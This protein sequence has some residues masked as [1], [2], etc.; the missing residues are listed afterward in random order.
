MQQ[1]NVKISLKNGHVIETTLQGESDREIK[2]QIMGE[3]GLFNE[4][5]AFFFK[6]HVISVEALKSNNT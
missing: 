6:E 2:N 1:Y 5:G 3:D 4:N